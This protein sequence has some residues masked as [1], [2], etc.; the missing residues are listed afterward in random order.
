MINHQVLVQGV[1]SRST[2]CVVLSPGQAAQFSSLM[3]LLTPFGFKYT[4]SRLKVPV[5]FSFIHRDKWKGYFC[6]QSTNFGYYRTIHGLRC[7]MW[8][9]PVFAQSPATCAISSY[10]MPPVYRWQKAWAAFSAYCPFSPCSYVSFFPTQRL[11]RRGS[12]L[13][14]QCIHHRNL[15]LLI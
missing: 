4:F 1:L 5:S 2:A 8:E 12:V 10:K 15:Q 11:D 13:A 9:S 6:A 14:S 7:V 3:S